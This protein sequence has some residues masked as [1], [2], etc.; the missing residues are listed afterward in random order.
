[1]NAFSVS[2]PDVADPRATTDSM[3]QAQHVTSDIWRMHSSTNACEM[4]VADIIYILISLS[5]S[6]SLYRSIARSFSRVPTLKLLVNA[7]S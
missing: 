6:L 3:L 5:L 7:S 1:M 4:S 2:F